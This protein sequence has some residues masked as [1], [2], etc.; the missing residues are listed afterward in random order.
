MMTSVRHT[1]HIDAPFET[2]YKNLTTIN[3]LSGW[4]TNFTSGSAERD[5]E[6]VFAFGE[7]AK[8]TFKVLTTEPNKKVVWQNTEGMP[9][10]IDSKITFNLSENDNKVKVD[11]IHDGFED[12]KDFIAHINFSWGRFMISFRDLCEKGEGQPFK[13]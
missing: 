10:W 7:M 11:F 4:W 8:M 6:I 9:T 13:G 2:V 12:P 5:G 1:F 3:G